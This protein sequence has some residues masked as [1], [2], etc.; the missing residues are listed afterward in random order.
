MKLRL[1]LIALL[2]PALACGS[3]SGGDEAKTTVPDITEPPPKPPEVKPPPPPPSGE[4]GE[5]LKE[6]NAGTPPAVDGTKPAVDG[7]KPAEAATTAEVTPGTEA[8]PAEP[9][10]E[11]ETL[12][13]KAIAKVKVS[14]KRE[15]R[16]AAENMAQKEAVSHGYTEATKVQ[17]GRVNCD[18]EWC[19]VPVTAVARRVKK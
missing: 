17:M 6:L 8:A 14:D 9:A 3:M 19:T 10:I 13:I 5:K 7:T 12:E 16:T 1:T 18:D 2:I 15:M 4:L 11:Y